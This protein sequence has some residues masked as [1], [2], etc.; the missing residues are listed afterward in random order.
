M[1]IATLDP[2]YENR[3]VFFEPEAHPYV[4]E[5]LAWLLPLPK[6]E[7][8]IILYTWVHAQGNNGKGRAG[9]AAIAYGP[10]LPQPIFEVV[11]GIF[12]SDDMGFDRWEVGP[13]RLVMRDGMRH[14][15]V[16]FHGDRVAVD[17]KFEGLNPSFA[18]GP[19]RGGCPQW[20]AYDRTEQGG[21]YEGMVR[22]G[23][24]TIEVNT[25]GHRDH[26]WGMR[27]WGG[28]LHWKWWNMLAAPDTSIHAM[29]IQAFGKTTLH[30]YVHKDG[31]TAT[32]TGLDADYELDD[33]F[34]HTSVH[35]VFHDD[36]GRKTTV[37]T[38][39][40]ADLEWP[41]STRLTIHEAAMHA[42]VDG[43]EGVAYVEMAWPPEYIAHHRG[44]DVE[45]M[46]SDRTDL[47]LDKS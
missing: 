2:T 38:T 11:D 14:S 7:L 26:S 9:A 44:Q 40:A 45:S 22:V 3:H 33:R 32:L 43:R 15:H 31:L 30:G 37:L 41:V 18:Y 6:H 35:A 42:D 5:S 29:E 46:Y 34:M 8:G 39:G 12:V 27:D 17:Y 13:M 23:D 28:P 10:N 16:V 36:A 19:N 21:R 25:L 47:T 4:R 24:R 1:P 20:L